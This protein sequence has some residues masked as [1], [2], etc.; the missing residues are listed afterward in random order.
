LAGRGGG[1]TLR[2]V[3][4]HRET[5]GRPVRASRRRCHDRSVVAPAPLPGPDPA[6]S[7][8]EKAATAIDVLRHAVAWF[9]A[10]GVTVQRVLSDNGSAYKSHAWRD[11]CIQLGITAKK[12]RPYRP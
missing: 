4:A 7:D 5:L 11:A 8:D 9:A 2:G 3:L 12:T 6:A 1:T 10:C